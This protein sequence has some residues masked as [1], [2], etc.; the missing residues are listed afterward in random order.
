MTFDFKELKNDANFVATVDHLTKNLDA[1]EESIRAA[2]SFPTTEYDLMPVEEK[3]KYDS[4][5]SYTIN[6][7]YWMYTRLQ[8]MDANSHGIKNELSRVRQSMIREKQLEDR[9]L[10]P[11]V[12]TSVAGRFIKHGLYDKN[13]KKRPNKA[14][15][16]S[17]QPQN[18]KIRFPENDSD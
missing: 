4:Y 8:G 12:N 3:V 7:L 13:D 15:S 10:R 18:K 14:A 16:S 6:S 11:Q 9:K 1:V 2:S 5:M 17:Q